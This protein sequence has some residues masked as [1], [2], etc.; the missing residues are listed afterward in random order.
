[1]HQVHEQTFATINIYSESRVEA[2]CVDS[3]L[4]PAESF[5]LPGL[6]ATGF[7]NSREVFDEN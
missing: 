1:M 4:K 6:K 3:R 2:E 5:F 7:P